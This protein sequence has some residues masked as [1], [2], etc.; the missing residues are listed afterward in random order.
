MCHRAR[1]VLHA[2][3]GGL[4]HQCE[5]LALACGE[6]LGARELAA[7]TLD[8]RALRAEI[9][10]PQIELRR[11]HR[12]PGPFGLEL[13]ASTL[14]FAAIG[15]LF[16]AMLVR[17]RSRDV[18]LPVLLYPMTVPVMIAGVR[19][20]A[21]LFQPEAD[22]ALAQFWIALLVFFDVVFVTLALWTFEPLMT[23]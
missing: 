23:D 16:A 20:T 2:G 19:G 15:T 7:Q 6:H 18:L 22:P 4:V 3:L 12:E 1:P 5:L 14:G 8:L 10:L 17:A 13:C 11:G 21:A 9:L